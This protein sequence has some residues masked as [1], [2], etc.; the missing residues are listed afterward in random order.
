MLVTT[1]TTTTSA[2]SALAYH[3]ARIFTIVLSVLLSEL[4]VGTL[5]DLTTLIELIGHFR[6]VIFAILS[7]LHRDFLKNHVVLSQR[8][9]LVRQQV[10]EA[11]KFFRDCRVASN[12]PSDVLVIFNLVL[13]EKFGEV[14]VDSHRDRDDGAEE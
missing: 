13:V 1:V 3:G 6:D 8:A 14:E 12:G 9:G 11:A 2:L 5:R 10:L 7:K 4:T